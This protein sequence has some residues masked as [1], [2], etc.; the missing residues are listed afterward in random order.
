MIDM[1][2]IAKY[3]FLLIVGGMIYGACELLFRG[4]TFGSMIIVGGMCFIVAGLLNEVTKWTTPLPLQ[5][6]L[7]AVAITMIEFVAGLILNVWLDLGV[8]DYS[9][10]KWNICGQIC[11]QFFCV[12][13][14]LSLPA[15]LLDDF[16]RWKLFDEEKPRYYLTFAKN[17]FECQALGANGICKRHVECC[18]MKICTFRNK[19]ENCKNYMF[20][21]SQKPCKNCKE[22]RE[23]Q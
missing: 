2:Q 16:I 13:V 20:P 10:M 4:Y 8:W 12:W 5:M 6:L 11:P 21:L 9:H 18:A 17:N 23:R 15:I 3:L 7:S 22:G 1:K 19:C 14:V